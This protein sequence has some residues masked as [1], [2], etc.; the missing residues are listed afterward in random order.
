MACNLGAT[1]V[2]TVFNDPL[3]YGDLYQWGRGRDGHEKRDSTI[4]TELSSGDTPGHDEF[5]ATGEDAYPMDWREE[6]NDDLW[7]GVDGINNPCPTGFRLPTE[8]EW[9]AEL[10]QYGTDQLALF[11]SPLK[12]PATGY[13]R[14]DYGEFRGVDSIAQYWSS[15]H[16]I[17]SAA[18]FNNVYPRYLLL[19]NAGTSEDLFIDKAFRANG[20]AVR[21]IQD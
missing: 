1:Q 10:D 19:G 15:S 7:Q 13:R 8:A 12:L 20:Q 11:N 18:P 17:D 16:T 14:G 2:A 21:C 6:L 4:T 5:I 9:Q 3:S